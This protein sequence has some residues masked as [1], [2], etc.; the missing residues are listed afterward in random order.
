MTGKQVIP[1][2]NVKLFC[3]I[4]EATESTGLSGYYIRQGIK[5]GRIPHIKSGNKYLVN[6]RLFLSMLDN[7][8]MEG[9][10]INE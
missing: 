4:P 3:T 9:G 7:L 8:S 5:D 10:E 1:I 2:V 6:M